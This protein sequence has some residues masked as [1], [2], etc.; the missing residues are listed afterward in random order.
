MDRRIKREIWEWGEQAADTTASCYKFTPTQYWK[1]VY[2][3]QPTVW[4]CSMVLP[5]WIT[6]IPFQHLSTCTFAVCMAGISFY[7]LKF[8]SNLVDN[9]SQSHLCFTCIWAT[10]YIEMCLWL[11]MFASTPAQ[12]S[13]LTSSLHISWAS[14]DPISVAGILPASLQPPQFSAPHTLHPPILTLA[15][16]IYT[17]KTTLCKTWHTPKIQCLQFPCLANPLCLTALM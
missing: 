1:Q 5:H 2:S 16:P 15:S 7:R 11:L 10:P 14:P 9:L 17:Y 8:C 4:T 3:T 12:A 6:D 13:L